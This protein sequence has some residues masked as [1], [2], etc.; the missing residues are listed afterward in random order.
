MVCERGTVTLL[1]LN[2]PE[3]LNAV[4]LPLYTALERSLTS[5][6]EDR[7]IRAVVLTGTGRAF[8][9]G[10]DL[11]AHGGDGS[12][13]EKRTYVEM[14]QRVHRLL[15]T[16]PQ[17]FVAAVNGAAVGAGLEIA[18]A[19]DLVVVAEDARLRFPELSLG[20]FVGGGT[21]YLLVQRVGLG[22]AKELLMLGE[23]FTGAEAAAMGL[24]NR[25]VPAERV[26]E[27]ATALAE[28]LAD[29]APVPMALV[30]RLLDQ[31]RHLDAETALALE[32]DALLAC[33]GSSDWQ[34][35]L[36]AFREKRVPRFIGE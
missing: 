11:V 2:R 8:C 5:I 31:A 20:T 32:A 15:Q 36:R 19:C 30:K 23:F 22:R 9:S 16:L 14:G 34:E 17:P 6:A 18:L 28:E 13:D 1:R 26:L 21:T 10:A 35:G 29:R 3:R 24:A 12:L 33:M 7:S 25:A 4:N 27:T